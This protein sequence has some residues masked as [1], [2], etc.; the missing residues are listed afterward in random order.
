MGEIK[1]MPR[2]LPPPPAAPADRQYRNF[3]P[4]R[5]FKQVKAELNSNTF[6]GDLLRLEIAKRNLVRAI[7]LHFVGR[8]L[9]KYL[10]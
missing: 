6:S 7:G 10:R 9:A 8:A 2:P 4:V 3:T 5:T 1:T